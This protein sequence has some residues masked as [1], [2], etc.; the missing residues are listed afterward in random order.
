MNLYA[1]ATRYQL[2]RLIGGERGRELKLRAEE[3][4]EAQGVRKPDAFVGMLL[5]GFD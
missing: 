1:A 3:W 4:L 2:G 5:P